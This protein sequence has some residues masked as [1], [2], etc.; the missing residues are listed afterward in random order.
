MRADKEWFE[1]IMKQANGNLMT[2]LENQI[3]ADIGGT[4]EQAN[5]VANHILDILDNAKENKEQEIRNKAIDE[6]AER[7]KGKVLNHFKYRGIIEEPTDY[8]DYI[9]EI[10][11]EMRSAK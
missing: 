11:E 6:F 8:S 7:L 10:A 1:I 5:R 3:Q 4:R 9:D 2:A